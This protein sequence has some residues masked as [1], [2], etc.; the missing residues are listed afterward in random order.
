MKIFEVSFVKQFKNFKIIKEV[1]IKSS[2]KNFS[3]NFSEKN[4]G[5]HNF[6]NCLKNIDARVYISKDYFTRECSNLKKLLKSVL[7]EKNEI[8]GQK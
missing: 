4:T 8:N 1:E 6:D 7:T 3:K 5:L 2:F